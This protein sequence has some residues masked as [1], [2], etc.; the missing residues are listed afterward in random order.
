V[1]IIVPRHGHSAVLRNRLKRRL[2]EIVRQDFL[3][4]ERAV[5]VVVRTAPTAYSATFAELR[6]EMNGALSRLR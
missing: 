6:S 3:A 1:G 4:G 2:R 5:D